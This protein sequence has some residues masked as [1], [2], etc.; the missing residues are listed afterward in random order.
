MTFPSQTALP[1][2]CISWAT[3]PSLA[4]PFA[5]LV[6]YVF[7]GPIPRFLGLGMRLNDEGVLV[8]TV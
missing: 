4:T 1:S 8:V 2:A 5:W 6:L 3:L 7:L